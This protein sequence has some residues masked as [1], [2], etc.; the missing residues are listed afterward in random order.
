MSVFPELG[1]ENLKLR[2]VIAGK[3]WHLFPQGYLI[4]AFVTNC[5]SGRTLRSHPTEKGFPFSRTN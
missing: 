3:F 2:H 5:Y 4:V 1:E